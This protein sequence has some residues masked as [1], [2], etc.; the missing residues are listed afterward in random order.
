VDVTQQNPPEDLTTAL[1]RPKGR[2]LGAAAEELV[3]T[4]SSKKPV[5]MIMY[6]GG[7]TYMELAALRFLSK[8]ASFPYHIVCCTTKVI[9]GSRVL[10]T[11][12]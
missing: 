10:Q 11:L 9:N 2:S 12:S 3:G 7:V 5:L 6:V 1:R 4:V 8:R